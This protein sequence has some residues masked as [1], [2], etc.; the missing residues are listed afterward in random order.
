[1]RRGGRRSHPGRPLHGRGPLVCQARGSIDPA[2]A[3]VGKR[4]WL[5]WKEDANAVGLPT[6]IW[7]I[8]LAPD[9]IHLNGH[10]RLLLRDEG[11]WEGSI[12]EAP[13]LIAHGGHLYLF[14]SGN[15]CCGSSCRYGLGVPRAPA[16]GGPWR[17][18]PSNPI[19][20]GNRSWK[21]PGHATAIPGPGGDWYLLYHAYQREALSRSASCCST[22]SI[23][24]TAGRPSTA[25]EGRA[26]RRRARLRFA[27]AG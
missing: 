15:A 20:A 26:R 23:G 12:V 5:L 8:P 1:M 11:G 10:R 6:S 7:A 19:L 27:S 4:R 22:A 21:C 14:Y 18:A 24:E 3:V 25:G 2:V 17:R 9:G 13:E 16:I